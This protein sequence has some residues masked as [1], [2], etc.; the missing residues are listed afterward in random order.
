MIQNIKHIIAYS[1][2]TFIVI[3]VLSSVV[4][5]STFYVNQD[6]FVTNFC[7]NKAQPTL[8]C[9]ATCHL[10]KV[11][12]VTEQTDSAAESI[13]IAVLSFE[14]LAN[15]SLAYTLAPFVF[16]V[17]GGY[18]NLSICFYDA[19]IEEKSPPPQV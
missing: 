17:E 4:V 15:N 19:L 14:F 1:F 11:L 5:I 12:S 9:K 8:C 3:N 13:K 10:K 18:G 16:E 2:I 6:F 7:V